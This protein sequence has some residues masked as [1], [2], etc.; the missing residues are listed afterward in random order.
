MK[1]PL[2]F[3]LAA[4]LICLPSILLHGCAT[5][6]TVTEIP[7]Y[8]LEGDAAIVH[9]MASPCVDKTSLHLTEQTPPHTHGKWKHVSSTWKNK[10]GVW[11]DFAGCWYDLSEDAVYLIFSDGAN[12][13]I[14]KS[15]FKAKGAG[16]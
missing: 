7:V 11:E 10:Q 1:L 9:M 2:W 4:F 3:K 8:V 6:A 12:G 14:S 5:V 13:S 15:E 16:T